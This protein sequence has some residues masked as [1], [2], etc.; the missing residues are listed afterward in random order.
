MGARDFRNRIP[1][2][3]VRGSG[4]SND[5]SGSNN[6]QTHTTSN[7]S[8]KPFNIVVGKK[9]SDGLLSWKGADLTHEFYI[10]KVDIGAAAD[11]LRDWIES[12]GEG[13]RVV[14]LEEIP[15]HHKRF[16]SF[17]LVMRKKDAEKIREWAWPEGVEV[18]RFFAKS[19]SG[20]GARFERTN[21]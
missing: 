21:S 10:T 18:R 14:D 4:G 19:N 11:V 6:Q 9:V 3:R 15:Q 20:G 8:R 5:N 17:K 7:R 13:V 12:Q 2:N 16:K 1:S